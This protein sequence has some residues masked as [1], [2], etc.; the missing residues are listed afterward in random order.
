MKKRALLACSLIVPLAI[1]WSGRSTSSQTSTGQ[2]PPQQ[3]APKASPTPS[4]TESDDDVVKISTN[5][6]QVDVILPIGTAFP[7]LI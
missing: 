1:L 6:V 4:Q 3:Q 2:T 5:L 7:S